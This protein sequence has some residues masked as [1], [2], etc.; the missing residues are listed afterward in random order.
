[1]TH[2]SLRTRQ[3]ARALL[4]TGAAATA[5]LVA[6]GCATTK[7]RP[8]RQAGPAASAASLP[9][10]DVG[11]SPVDSGPPTAGGNA[12]GNGGGNGGAGQASPSAS[13]SGGTQIVYFR[14]KQQPKC[15]EGTNVYH[16]PAV[17]AI[18]EWKV[19]GATKVALSVDNPNLV[20]AYQTYDGTQGSET[21]TFSCGG[22]VGSIETHQYTINTVGGPGKQKMT[23][24]VS[25]KVLE[26]GTP[27]T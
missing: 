1:M 18:I 3:A 19:T 8:A 2:G 5:L 11:L 14:V 15:E 6:A 27:V 24:S 10:P 4:L 13:Q 23:I 9:D 17:P 20:G 25:A 22:T 7:P 21:F 16:S 26:K 12:G